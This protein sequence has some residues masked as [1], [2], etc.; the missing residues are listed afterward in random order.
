MEYR[1]DLG[2]TTITYAF[3]TNE[4]VANLVGSFDAG[5]EY[6]AFMLQ[7]VVN[8]HDLGEQIVPFDDGSMGKRMHPGF[9]RSLSHTHTQM[10]E[11]TSQSSVYTSILRRIKAECEQSLR[12]EVDEAYVSVQGSLDLKARQQIR[13]AGLKAGLKVRAVI[14]QVDAAPAAYG[15]ENA[16]DKEHYHI[17]VEYN[18]AS[19]G[20]ALVNT[21]VG[22]SETL[23][24]STD[25]WHGSNDFDYRMAHEFVKASSLGPKDVDQITGDSVA[26]ATIANSFRDVRGKNESFLALEEEI[27]VS[28]PK[29]RRDVGDF[30]S[31]MSRSRFRAAENE[32]FESAQTGI[33]AFLKECQLETTSAASPDIPS[34][35]EVSTVMFMGDALA[36][37]FS[38]LREAVTTAASR[39]GLRLRVL[40]S[41]K[42]AHVAALG[43]AMSAARTLENSERIRAYY[44]PD[45]QI[46]DEL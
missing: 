6:R 28:V 31:T 1:I 19:L 40:D 22:I 43:A 18:Q 44:H 20:L 17:V 8:T 25:P 24:Y 11:I 23:V 9:K 33:E 5:D 42:P 39:S 13:D 34:R 45:G 46:H 7:S 10:Q 35:D 21:D 41:V 12:R 2:M 29:I 37:S 27:V 14:S 15:L 38:R 32:Y 3:A 16:D 26:M 36:A 30:E 4:S